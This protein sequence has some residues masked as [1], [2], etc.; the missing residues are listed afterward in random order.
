[1]YLA[2]PESSNLS[3]KSDLKTAKFATRLP[4]TCDP[5]SSLILGANRKGPRSHLASLSL[6]DR[7][8]AHCN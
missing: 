4:W 2:T 6:L 7:T 5:Y 1:L 3:T 8:R